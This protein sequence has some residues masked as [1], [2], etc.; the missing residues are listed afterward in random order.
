[1][2]GRRAPIAASDH[3]VYADLL[4]LVVALDRVPQSP[5]YH[6]EGDALYHSLQVF[7]HARRE[8]PDPCL[9]AAAL[10]HDVGKALRC[11]DHDA[12]GAD[13]LEGLVAPRVVWLVRHHLDLLR[14][15]GGT[16]RRLHN[17][18][19]LRDLERLRR[20]DLAG[21]S[22]RAH[23]CSPEEAVAFVTRDPIAL[24]PDAPR[25]VDPS[26]EGTVTHR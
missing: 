24:H 4:E 10:L 2:G 16:R 17:T 5:R 3:P 20:W 14:D 13:L 22:P 23:V 9:H 12:E 21:R 15:P 26:H 18:V 1:V 8:S 25:V 11:P 7:Q 19:N 6:P